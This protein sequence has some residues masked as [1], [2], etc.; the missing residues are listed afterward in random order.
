MSADSLEDWIECSYRWFVG[1]ELAPQRLEPEADPLWLGGVV[2]EALHRLYARAS[3][4]GRDPAARQTSA[5]WKARFTELARRV[6]VER[7]RVAA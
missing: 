6:V 4:R 7:D 1:H 5:R 2:H 3:G